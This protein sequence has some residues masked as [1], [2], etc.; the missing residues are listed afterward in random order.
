MG[1]GDEDTSVIKIIVG[2]KQ[3]KQARE[4]E[5]SLFGG[6][7]IVKSDCFGPNVDLNKKIEEILDSI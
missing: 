1:D 3:R 2:N 4:Q 5:V 7:I 6:Q